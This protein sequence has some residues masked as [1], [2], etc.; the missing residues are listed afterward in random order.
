MH[1][2]AAALITPSGVPPTPKRMSAPDSGQPVEM[3]PATSPSWMR[4]MRAPASRISAMS[5]SCRGRSRTT[6]VMSRTDFLR[7]E[8]A[9]LRLSVGDWVMSIEPAASAPTASLSM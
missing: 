4:R 2:R 1:L 8:A 5:L 7:A 3:A 6:A 9:D